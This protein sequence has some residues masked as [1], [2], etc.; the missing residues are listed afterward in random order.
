MT[1]SILLVQ[2]YTVTYCK[3]NIFA[4]I[5]QQIYYGFDRKPRKSF[6]FIRFGNAVLQQKNG[7]PFPISR[8]FLM[9]YR[10]AVRCNIKPASG[11]V[12]KIAQRFHAPA[13]CK[14]KLTGGLQSAAGVE[15]PFTMCWIIVAHIRV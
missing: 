15:I 1:Y 13:D 5:C 9:Q 4:E 12:G 6:V 7:R 10:L 14:P 2:R 11:R 3:Y 8:A